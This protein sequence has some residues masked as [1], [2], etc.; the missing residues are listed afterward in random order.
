MKMVHCLEMLLK[1]LPFAG[2]GSECVVAKKEGINFIG[3]EIN[4]EYVQLCNHRLD[5]PLL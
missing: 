2:S 1:L 3:Y 4:E 5:E